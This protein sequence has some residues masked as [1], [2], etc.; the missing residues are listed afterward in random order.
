M[1]KLIVIMVGLSGVFLLTQKYCPSL[2]NTGPK[3]LAFDGFQPPWIIL[4]GIGF[5]LLAHKAK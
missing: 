3:M 1:L 2:L 4:I 5:V